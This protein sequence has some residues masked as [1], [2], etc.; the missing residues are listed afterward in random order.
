MKN[1]FANPAYEETNPNTYVKNLYIYPSCEL[2]DEIRFDYDLDN[3]VY[4]DQ[5]IEYCYRDFE[6]SIYTDDY[7]A[8]VLDYFYYKYLIH[9]CASFARQLDEIKA[10]TI[11]SYDT[12]TDT[13]ICVFR[14]TKGTWCNIFGDK[15][16]Y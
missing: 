1:I 11:A 6:T 2:W 10:R 4:R 13:D 3:P 12:V 7:K 9:N 15:G 16:L 8:Y 14:K 5:D